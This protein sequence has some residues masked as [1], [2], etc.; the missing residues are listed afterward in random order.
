MTQDAWP[1]VQIAA[2]EG[3]A[4]QG[5]NAASEAVVLDALG[6]QSRSVR[7]AA[8]VA[9]GKQGNLASGPTL[10]ELMENPEED[11]EL[12]AA[13]ASALGHLCDPRALDSLTKL[14]H[15]LTTPGTSEALLRVAGEAVVAL[16]QLHPP[17]L[18]GRLAPLLADR[19]HPGVPTAAR[20]ALADKRRCAALTK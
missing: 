11:A 3:L 14:A 16:G 4:L 18:A 6:S 1:L 8:V 10:L 12:R 19:V 20:R 2:L 17:D 15:R 5:P 7:R 13:A 9:M